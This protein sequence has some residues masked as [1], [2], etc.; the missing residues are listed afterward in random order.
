MSRA[1]AEALRRLAAGE[2]QTDIAQSY[3]V[4]HLTIGRLQERCYALSRTP[5]S[6]RE[7]AEF[8]A[9]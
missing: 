6:S 7:A 1:T 4:S 2:T 5:R 9:S 8:S 3:N